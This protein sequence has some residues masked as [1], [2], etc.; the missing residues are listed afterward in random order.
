MGNEPEG[1]PEGAVVL[2]DGTCEI[3]GKTATDG[4]EVVTTKMDGLVLDIGCGDREIV[5]DFILAAGL[6]DGIK[7]EKKDVG[8]IVDACKLGLSVG[9]TDGSVEGLLLCVGLADS[10]DVGS[11]EV[12]GITDSVKIGLIESDN[13]GAADSFTLVVG[14]SDVI[15]VGNNDVE[16]VVDTCKLC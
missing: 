3:V 1:I 7:V 14:I 16:G 15:Q 2:N 10:L 13:D 6:S 9:D 5:D 8:G 4:L 11:V 12:D